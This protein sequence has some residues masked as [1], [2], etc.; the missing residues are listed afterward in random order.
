MA[1]RAAKESSSCRTARGKPA[2]GKMADESV[3]KTIARKR[4]MND[5][6]LFYFST[7]ILRYY[8]SL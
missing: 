3:G 8:L 1:N 6:V 4:A 7:L 5:R 2:S